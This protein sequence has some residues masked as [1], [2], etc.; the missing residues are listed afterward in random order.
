[1]SNQL[2]NRYHTDV[3]RLIQYGGRV[4]EAV[5]RFRRDIP[6]VLETLRRMIVEQ[7]GSND[8]FRA[9][10]QLFHE[11]CRQ[12]INADLTL[13]DVNEML[14]Q[15]ILTEEIFISIFS[16]A[17]F[18]RENNIAREL[19][20]VEETFFIGQTKRE[21]LDGIRDYYEMITAQATGIVSHHEKQQFLKVTYENF[22][23]AYNPKGADRLGIVYTPHEIVG[24]MIEGV[25]HLL[26][27]HFGRTLGDENVEVLDPATGSGTFICDIIDYLPTGKVTHKYLKELHANEI[28]I[29]PYYIANLNIEYTFKQKTGHYREFPHICFVD[30]LDNTGG[31][32]H[33]GHQQGLFGFSAENADRIKEQ[34]ERK[35]SVIIGNPPYNANQQNENDNCVTVPPVNRRPVCPTESL[36]A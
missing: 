28:A 6:V 24:F 2:I 32:A 25:D 9:R 8:R 33:S 19:Y 5:Q 27:K 22:Y 7:E 10:R 21:T 1:M 18:H 30:T 29:L 16:D 12:S 23:K 15:H 14:I 34:N 13:A 17:S 20:Q 4:N 26:D 31:L 3:D 11:L 35:I 36:S